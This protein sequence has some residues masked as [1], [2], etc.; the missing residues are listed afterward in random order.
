MLKLR[1]IF[2]EF[3]NK[4]SAPKKFPS[5]YAF[6]AFSAFYTYSLYFFSKSYLKTLNNF[7][8]MLKN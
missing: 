8:W 3:R 1:L 2:I 7:I 6:H 4:M 5:D